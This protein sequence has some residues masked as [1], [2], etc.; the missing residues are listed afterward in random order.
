ME[1]WIY[2]GMVLEAANTPQKLNYFTSIINDEI[3]ENEIEKK[4]II[5][6]VKRRVIM[7]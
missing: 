1:G 7:N 6:T 3:Y 4:T 5:I 2:D